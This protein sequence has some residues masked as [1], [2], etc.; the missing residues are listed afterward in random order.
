MIKRGDIL[1]LGI[2]S[3]T[4]GGLTGGLLLGAGFNLV[5]GGMHLGWLLVMPAAPI[6][7]FW[8]WIMAR[9]LISRENLPN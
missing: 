3:G 8:G 6:S 1:W 4:L 2:A 7:A 5:S 9:K